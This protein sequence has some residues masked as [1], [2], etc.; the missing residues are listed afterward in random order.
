VRDAIDSFTKAIDKGNRSADAYEHL[1]LNLMVENRFPEAVK[2]LAKAAEADAKRARIWAEVG[3]AQQQA[4]DLEGA[5][6]N[7]QRALSQDPSLPSVW[8]KLGIAYK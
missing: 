4:G 7:F 8:T 5:I 6:R 1:G 3:D 2:A